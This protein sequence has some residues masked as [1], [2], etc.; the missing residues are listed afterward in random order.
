MNVRYR[1]II[2]TVPFLI[3][4]LMFASPIG[5]PSTLIPPDLRAL[6]GLNPLAGLI[7]AFRWSSTNSTANPWSEFAVSLSVTFVLLVMGLA[8]FARSEC[9]FA[10]I[11]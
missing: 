4:A 9:S 3:Q 10:D 1:D 6:Y 8:Y 2:Y 5:Y 7:E 11:I